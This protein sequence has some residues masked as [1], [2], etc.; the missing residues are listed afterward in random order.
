MRKLIT[1]LASMAALGLVGC[2]DD[3]KEDARLKVAELAEISHSAD[4]CP[5][6]DGLYNRKEGFTKG[7]MGFNIQNGERLQLA[8][9][10]T[11]IDGVTLILDGKVHTGEENG[12]TMKYVAG[13][14]DGKLTLR[15][16]IGD[17]K[18]DMEITE[19]E[20]GTARVHSG[21]DTVVY[22]KSIK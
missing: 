20:G 17:E 19:D 15:G 1:L 9:P 11:G 8:T 5:K 22:E 3:D 7:V 6:T 14:D 21:G 12:R 13:C 10:V 2:S 18:I 4:E 16:S